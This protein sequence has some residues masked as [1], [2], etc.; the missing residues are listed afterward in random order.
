MSRKTSQSSRPL[1]HASHDASPSL[2]SKQRRSS[3]ESLSSGGSAHSQA[4]VDFVNSIINDVYD[5]EVPTTTQAEMTNLLG[6]LGPQPSTNVTQNLSVEE[7]VVN[8]EGIRT[9]LDAASQ[10][11]T[12]HPQAGYIEEHQTWTTECLQ[13]M[14]A[15]ST[16][17]WRC[18][19]WS[20]PIVQHH[21]SV[22]VAPSRRRFSMEGAVR[23]DP[24]GFRRNA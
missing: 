5:P 19:V 17:E 4:S 10:H 8:L 18:Q 24:S 22:R 23:M 20:N 15:T 3:R 2:T 6:N 7:T 12:T 21:A 11:F 14:P 16:L 13:R 1:S 9:I